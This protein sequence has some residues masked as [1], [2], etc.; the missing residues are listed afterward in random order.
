MVRRRLLRAGVLGSLVISVGTLVPYL[1]MQV[2]AI[3]RLYDAADAP[4]ADVLLVL[5][6]QVNPDGQPSRYLTGRLDT[7]GELL[8][9]GRA[10]VALVSGDGA[11]G[12]TQA[13]TRY[14]IDT[15][16]I[17]ANRVV[18]D[19]YGL[20]TYD[21]CVR[22]KRVYGLDH[23]TVVTQPFHLSRAVTLC[24]RAGIDA[25]G[26]RADCGCVFLGQIR[27]G[28]RDYLAS[29]KAVWDMITDRD[30]AVTSSP[31]D[32]VKRAG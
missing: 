4:T 11:H 19:P 7:A 14:L 15:L 16:G 9:S 10:R 6:A 27:N 21:S 18:S 8:R 12:E 5:G 31:N 29:T 23:L 25:V 24:R 2:G 20:D 22:A 13:M 3:G 17:D 28:L 1:V 30:P 26:V 32:A